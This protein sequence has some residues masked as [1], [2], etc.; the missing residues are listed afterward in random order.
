M[1]AKQT[2]VNG[3]YLTPA[4][5]NGY[6]GVSA[7][8]G[9][10]H[11]GGG[12]ATCAPKI[13]LS[14]SAN[15]TGQLPL[16]NIA[17]GALFNNFMTGLD[18][19]NVGIYSSKLALNPGSC[20]NSGNSCM[21]TLSSSCTK[22]TTSTWAE[23]TGVGG[24]ADGVVAG[25][26]TGYHFF[27]IGKSSDPNAV[28]AGFDLAES[29]YNL[30]STPAVVSAGYNIWRRVGFAYRD[31]YVTQIRSFVQ[32]GDYFIYD[33]ITSSDT[34]SLSGSTRT[35]LTLRAIPVGVSVQA[36]IAMYAWTANQ[37]NPANNAYFFDGIGAYTPAWVGVA[38]SHTTFDWNP[39]PT[40]GR[41]WTDTAA[42]IGVTSVSTGLTPA[43]LTPVVCGS[44]VLGYMDPR[45]K[46]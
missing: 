36:R 40:E 29:A 32:K 12:D 30:M 31:S 13:D 5:L 8:T 42:R 6:F 1:S 21:M 23:G 25:D 27:V 3:S 14:A 11:D 41:L 34:T 43:P 16:A 9:H 39:P 37:T 38:A 26:Q 45:G 22:D 10:V 33:N 44:I 35:T 18:T 46:Y 28:D 4:T 24:M 19:T 20:A 2:Y 17:Y 7:A 15:V